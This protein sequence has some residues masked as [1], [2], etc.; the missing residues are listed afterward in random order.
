M[1]IES[2]QKDLVDAF[3]H[4]YGLHMGQTTHILDILKPAS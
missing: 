3:K 1:T 2:I 4:L